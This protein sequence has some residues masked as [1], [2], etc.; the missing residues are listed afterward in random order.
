MEEMPIRSSAVFLMA[1]VGDALGGWGQGPCT[2]E[3]GAWFFVGSRSELLR[4]RFDSGTPFVTDVFHRTFRS[5]QELEK[6]TGSSLA[7]S[8]L[9][10]D[11]LEQSVKQLD[12]N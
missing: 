11:S 4:C 8:S 10:W 7:G 2:T 6:A 5:S 3:A 9:H 12:K 1:P